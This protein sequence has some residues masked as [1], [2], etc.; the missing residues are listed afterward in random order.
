[1]RA[2]EELKHDASSLRLSWI[3][4]VNVIPFLCPPIPLPNLLATF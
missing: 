4:T 1:M 2:Y 3:F